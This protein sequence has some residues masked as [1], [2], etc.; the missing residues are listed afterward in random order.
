MSFL[1]AGALIALVLGLLAA[2]LPYAAFNTKVTRPFRRAPRGMPT[3]IGRSS[4]Q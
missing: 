2:L 1:L 3:R 4:R